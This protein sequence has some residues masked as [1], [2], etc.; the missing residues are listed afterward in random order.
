MSAQPRLALYTTV[1][2]QMFP[3]FAD[4]YASL[5]VQTDRDV[6]IWIGLDR[7]R[8][9]QVWELAGERFAFTPVVVD[10]GQS[11]AGLRQKA[12]SRMAERYF[13]I[14]FT[15]A[16]DWMMPERVSQARADLQACDVSA[17]A[18]RIVSTAG[19]D[20]GQVFTMPPGNLLEDNLLERNVFGLSNTAYRSECLRQLL[21]IP[22]HAVLVDWLLATRAWA[23]GAR[24]RFNPTVLMAYRQYEQN[25][26]RVLPPFTPEQVLRGARLVL[27]HYDLM[28]DG[29]TRLAVSVQA[30][31]EAARQR[32]M[33]FYEKML[34]EAQKLEAYTEALNALP[35]KHIW[36]SFVAHP[37]LE[38]LWKS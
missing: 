35:P 9:S 14:I 10:E 19:S 28:L 4:W 36:W 33:G 5:Q 31:L 3:Y 12:F 29:Q 22:G 2:P 20:T 32:A 38:E 1:Y 7:V 8:Q 34:A 6:D 37:Q 15:D 16:D 27:D 25:T 13:G 17:C 23:M 21:P 30:R 26:A 18:M 24:M 11:V